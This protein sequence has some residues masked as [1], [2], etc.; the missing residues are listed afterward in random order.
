MITK[1]SFKGARFI[2]DFI[3]PSYYSISRSSKP[4][5]RSP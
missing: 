1:G 3:I 4:G 5:D 2:V